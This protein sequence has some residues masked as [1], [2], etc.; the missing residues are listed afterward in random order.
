[1]VR[2]MCNCGELP[3]SVVELEYH[4]QEFQFQR[5]LFLNHYFEIPE[6]DHFEPSLDYSQSMYCCLDCGQSW[7]LECTPEE[8]PSP[9]FALK[10][11]EPGV[12]PSV[13]EIQAMKH[14]LSIVAHGGFDS[15]QCRMVDCPNNKLL[16]RELCHLH[17]PFP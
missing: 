3:S 4:N 15:E 8:N 5:E 14:Y 11:D 7:Y 10:V 16:G 1:M 6:S 2:I 12:L 17:T 13:K 9:L